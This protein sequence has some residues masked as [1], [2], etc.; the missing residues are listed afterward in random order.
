MIITLSG[1]GLSTAMNFGLHQIGDTFEF[2]EVSFAFTT[3]DQM[4]SIESMS[5]KWL[6]RSSK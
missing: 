2:F 4:K 1:S 5:A 3:G 6:V